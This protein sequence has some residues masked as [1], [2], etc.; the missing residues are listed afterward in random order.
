MLQGV[1]GIATISDTTTAATKK[2]DELGRDSFLT[3]FL[4][5]LK[6]QDPLN[7][8]DGQEFAAQLAQFTSLEQLYNVNENLEAM[9]TSQNQNSRFQALDFIG[10]DIQAGGNILSL[11][12]DQT[13]KGGFTIAEKAYCT[14]MVYDENG[15]PVRSI[16]LG[17]LESGPH[18]FVWDGVD[19]SGNRAAEG[20]YGFDIKAVTAGGDVLTAETRLIGR[21]TRVSLEGQSPVLYVGDLAVGLSQVLD[22]RL[23]ADSGTPSA[24]DPVE[25]PL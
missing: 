25:T 10:R 21:V 24:G 9:N 16:P 18:D 20:P 12:Q 5:Q 15:I 2:K 17:E 8:M 22:I 13:V 7:P 4:A 3:M 14:V 23:P 6:N 1:E 19:D 11:K